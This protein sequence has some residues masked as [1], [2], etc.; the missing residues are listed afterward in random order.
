VAVVLCDLEQ[1]GT[2]WYYQSV[3]LSINFILYTVRPGYI[4][5]ESI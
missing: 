3:N 1:V 5:N 2:V 4:L